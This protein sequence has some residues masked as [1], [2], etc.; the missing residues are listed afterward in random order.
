[1]TVKMSARSKLQ[2]SRPLTCFVT[3]EIDQAYRALAAATMSRSSDLQRR[4]HI[5]FLTSCGVLE[6]PNPKPI[7]PE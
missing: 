1:M 2:F 7:Q 3:P 4:A 6:L 5:A